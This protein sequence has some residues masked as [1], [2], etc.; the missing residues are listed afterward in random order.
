ME[1]SKRQKQVGQLVM[2][3]LSDIFQREGF[4]IVDG[5]MVSISKVMVTPDLLQARVYLSIFQVKDPE[6]LLHTIKDRAWDIRK[7]LGQR[8]RNQLR[9]VPELVFYNDD[10]LDYV[11]KMEELFKKINEEREE[12]EKN[13]EQ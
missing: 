11:F 4:N 9:N 7:Q 6:K 5:G 10:T 13:K 3:E 2:E 12:Q 1:E 8:V